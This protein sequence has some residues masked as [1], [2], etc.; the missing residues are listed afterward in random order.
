MSKKI[1]SLMLSVLFLIS[2]FN[3]HVSA[4]AN[5]QNDISGH[6]AKTY[7]EWSMDNNF[8]KGYPDGSFKPNK[9]MTK[10]E[11][12]S[13]MSN[14]IGKRLEA[15]VNYSDIKTSDWFYKDVKNLVALGILDN[16]GNFNPNSPITRDEA[17]RI[18]GAIYNQ[19][20]D[21]KSLDRFIDKDL[22]VNKKEIAALVNLGIISGNANGKLNPEATITRGEV[23]TVLEKNVSVLGK[24]YTKY[25]KQEPANNDSLVKES[26]KN[27]NKVQSIPVKEAE[28]KSSHSSG[29]WYR[30]YNPSEEIKP[31]KPTPTPPT[32]P[33]PPVPPVP[34][35]PPAKTEYTVTVVNDG[36]GS[37]VAHPVKGE[38]GTEVTLTY[39]P[40]E[41]YKFKEW[42]VVSGGVVIT[43]NSFTIGKSNVEVKAIFEKENP[44]PPTP[45]AKPK[46]TLTLPTGD[47]VTVENPSADNKY[48]EGTTVTFTVKAPTGKKIS[49]V[50]ANDVD[51]TADS[52]GKYSFKITK[53]T[54]INV[55]AE[56][57]T[58]AKTEYIVTVTSFENGTAS[59]S[60]SKGEKGT[61]VTLT[62]SANEGYQFKE[63]KV[64]KGN[65]TIADDKFYIGN[66]D[67]EIQAIFEKIKAVCPDET[68][69]KSDFASAV[70]S[71]L[72]TIKFEGA[73]LD[74]NKEKK[75]AQLII[76]D[77]DKTLSSVANT[78]A[79][80]A[81][82]GIVDN[83]GLKSFKIENREEKVLTNKK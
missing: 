38:E 58:S 25:Q 51:L 48:E 6:W 24:D 5:K 73:S 44:T 45:P 64:I 19:S 50:S 53:D 1:I 9:E 52:N 57:E 17:F 49:K 12:V 28:K 14:L 63:W 68:K 65:V 83:S 36:N 56:D 26:E 67:V 32:P 16:K 35:A 40:N 43:G 81:L 15:K 37:G 10:A 30:P 74:F 2:I 55:V 27:Q 66:E 4:E 76:T 8:F 31:D 62:E 61:E 59:A 71:A 34:P 33:T 22:I 70:D 78:G 47:I 82:K 77:V 80:K 3:T 13:V 42:Q 41:N 69:I 29:D 72:K 75:E 54:T 20:S 21:E 11:Y 79:A 7:I 46:Y 23:C 39:T 60:P 18:L